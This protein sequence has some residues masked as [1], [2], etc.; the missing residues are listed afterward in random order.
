MPAQT[1]F[2]DQRVILPESHRCSPTNGLLGGKDDG[3]TLNLSRTCQSPKSSCVS[4]IFGNTQINLL[5]SSSPARHHTLCKCSSHFLPGTFKLGESSK[6]RLFCFWFVGQ[7]V[8]SRSLVR[9]PDFPILSLTARVHESHQSLF[10]PPLRLSSPA[11]AERCYGIVVRQLT[12]FCG[13]LPAHL[14]CLRNPTS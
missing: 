7:R 9:K 5:A 2:D 10:P 11:S 4:C 14:G 8:V 13:L 12:S 6:A 3:V 1:C